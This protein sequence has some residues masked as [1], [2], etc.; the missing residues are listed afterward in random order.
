[1]DI[2]LTKKI[3]TVGKEK[4]ALV[5]NA[6]LCDKSNENDR[7]FMATLAPKLLRDMSGAV[8]EAGRVEWPVREL[9]VAQLR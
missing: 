9:G 4:C 2:S 6:M 7:S 5:E 3:L 1:M 8:E